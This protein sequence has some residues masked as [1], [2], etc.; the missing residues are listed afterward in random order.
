[1]FSPATSIPAMRL[2]LCILLLIIT[3]PL[4]AEQDA[5][6]IQ[7]ATFADRFGYWISNKHLHVFA[8]ADQNLRILSIHPRGGKNLLRPNAKGIGGLKTWLMEERE[9][10]E[11]RDVVSELPGT[12]EIL[13]GGRLLLQSQTHPE[14][15]LQLVWLIEMHLSQPWFR[16]IHR[17]VNHGSEPRKLALWALLAFEG[18]GHS[19]IDRFDPAGNELFL[20]QFAFNQM[21]DDRIAI[22][23]DRF[24]LNLERRVNAVGSVKI[25]VR[26]PSSRITWKSGGWSVTSQTPWI[27]ALYPDGDLNLTAFA[28]RAKPNTPHLSEIENVGPILLVQPGEGIELSQTIF[29]DKLK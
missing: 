27:D 13:P 11:F 24:G 8:T 9:T 28:V 7:G 6:R 4:C 16:V 2:T 10:I 20:Y 21:N 18:Y 15:Q 14:Q 29:V 22:E 19:S 26:N 23:G 17:V 25:G 1:M 5:V 12:I 3:G